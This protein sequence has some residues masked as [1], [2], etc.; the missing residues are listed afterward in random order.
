MVRAMCNGV[1]TF[2]D[3]MWNTR[4][5]F[6]V[7]KANPSGRCVGDQPGVMRGSAFEQIQ[8]HV[9]DHVF[10]TTDHPPLAQFD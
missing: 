9:D 4:F 3:V 1:I 7:G 10:L 2:S 5:I 6:V 8:R